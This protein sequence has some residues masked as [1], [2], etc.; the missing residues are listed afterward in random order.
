MDTFVR[1]FKLEYKADSPVDHLIVKTF[2][3]RGHLH[4]LDS[5][6][7]NQALTRIVL[8]S[9]ASVQDRIPL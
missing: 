1:L 2:C 6:I 9:I 7:A 3:L 5:D 4:Q 8:A